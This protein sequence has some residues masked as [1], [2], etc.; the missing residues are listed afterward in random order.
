[1]STNRHH[2]ENIAKQASEIT[3]LEER[4]ARLERLDTNHDGQI[5]HKELENW[6]KKQEKDLQSFRERIIQQEALKH[7]KALLEKDSEVTELRKEIASLKQLLEQCSANALSEKERL[8]AA[9]AS[10]SRSRGSGEEVEVEE[11]GDPG[12][13]AADTSDID[14]T[15]TKALSE[16]Q[17]RRFVEQL[18][19]DENV[20]IGY[21]P[22]WVERQLYINFFN[23]LIGLLR[24]TVSSTSIRFIG[25]E[26]SMVMVPMDTD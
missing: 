21:L 15:M 4:L 11:G 5:S 3:R 22:D 16:E 13:S 2:Q 9:L 18:L 19:A 23:L 7:Q 10:A 6:K 20:N 26:V 12:T 14:M 24:K 8:I 17:I 25:H 1:M